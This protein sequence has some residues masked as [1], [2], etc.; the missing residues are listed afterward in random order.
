MV[1]GGGGCASSVG[2]SDLEISDH[3]DFLDYLIDD[4]IKRFFIYSK[5]CLKDMTIKN[6]K[7]RLKVDRQN[8]RD[9]P[10]TST[11]SR[12]GYSYKPYIYV[13]DRK[14]GSLNRPRH[15]VTH[16][17]SNT[18]KNIEPNRPLSF[19]QFPHCESQMYQSSNVY[20]ILIGSQSRD[21]LNSNCDHLPAL[22]DSGAVVSVPPTSL[23]DCTGNNSEDE[24][25]F[26]EQCS[27]NIARQ[28]LV[29]LI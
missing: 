26:G 28:V 8:D 24:Y 7:D 21:I 16:V 29:F 15:R 14:D 12:H 27:G 19:S 1:S 13:D 2:A 18:N 3:S 5:F 6:R 23:D 20:P 22:C 4:F 10:D 9:T 17:E 25:Y 11:N